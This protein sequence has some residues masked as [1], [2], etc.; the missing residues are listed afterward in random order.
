MTLLSN[1]S[2][3]PGK[4]WGLQAITTCAGATDP[5][6][7]ELVPA[8]QGCYATDGN[9]RF[10]QVKDKRAFNKLDWQTDDW[11]ARMINELTWSST[12]YFRWF[13]VAVIVCSGILGISA[14]IGIL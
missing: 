8:C 3:M 6:T 9:Y 11:T 4:S 5:T 10:T 1:P 2:K 12:R 13:S 7:G 14:G